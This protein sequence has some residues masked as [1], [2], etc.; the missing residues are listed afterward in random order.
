MFIVTHGMTTLSIVL[1]A[2]QSFLVF[3]K[4]SAWVIEL[5]S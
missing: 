4:H 5:I 3:S 1:P 2:L